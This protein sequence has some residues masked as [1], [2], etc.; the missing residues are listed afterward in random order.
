[1]PYR[2][3]EARREAKRRYYASK[4][5]VRRAQRYRELRDAPAMQINPAPL[6]AALNHWRT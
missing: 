2:D 3:P 6:V 5:R 4:G 1:M